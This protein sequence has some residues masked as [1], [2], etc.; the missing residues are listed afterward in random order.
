MNKRHI[1]FIL[2]VILTT[3]FAVTAVAQQQG[4]GQS[5]A[6]REKYKYTFQLTTMVRHIGDID[7]DKKYTLTPSQAKQVL[8]I[9]TPWRTKPKMTQDQAKGVMRK[10]KTVFTA[11]QLNAMARIKSH[12][13]QGQ[14][15]GQGPPRDGGQ[16]RNRQS[17]QRHFD[18]NS[19][20]DFNP[21]YTKAPKGDTRAEERAKRW[22][23]F[24][25]AL[26]AKAKKK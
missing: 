23:E 18:P 2:A 17:G 20:K 19:M 15:P 14:R 1:V 11:G 8:G 5:S 13:G 4:G 16:D 10:L 7:K 21:F 24:F 6:M 26:Q 12:F 3:A 25:A 9:L 22:N